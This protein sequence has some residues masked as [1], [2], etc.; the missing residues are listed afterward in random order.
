MLLRN[1]QFTE[2]YLALTI[3]VLL[4]SCAIKSDTIS[5]SSSEKSQI[6]NNTHQHVMSDTKT[7]CSDELFAAKLY[8]LGEHSFPV[9]TQNQDAQRYMNQGLNFSYGFNHTEA[10]CAF[11]EAANLDPNLAMAYWGQALV[12]G[13]NINAEMNATLEMQAHTLVQQAK[14]LMQNISPREQVLINALE[15]RY[16]GHAKDRTTNNK[17][18]AQ[19]MR[20]A[21]QRFPDDQDIAVLFVEAVMDLHSWGYWMPDDTP[22]EGI[23]EIVGVTEQILKVNPK[24]PGAL[25]MYIHLMEST[26][27]P[28]KAEQ[29]ADTLL[30]LVPEAGHLVHMT[31]HIYQRVGR[32]ADAIKSNQMAIAVDESYLARC[33]DRGPYTTTYYPH[34]IHFLWYAA[35]LDGQSQLAIEAARKVASKVDDTML[36]EIP[37]TAFFRVT[38]YWALARF[39]YWQE[40]LR[41]PAPPASN[42]FLMGSWHYVRGLAQVATQ[43]I[44][45]AEQELA[46]LHTVLERL[47]KDDPIISKNSASSI[48]RIAAEVLAGEIAGAKN[49]FE[50]AILHLDK[51]IRLDDAL[52]YTEPPEFHFPP[53]LALGA[54]LLKAGRANEAETVYWEDLK[55][56]RNN[57][58]A[59]FGLT[60]ALTA[61]N[62]T[63][64]AAIVKERFEQSW[65]R[66]DVELKASRFGL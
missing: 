28:E 21:H 61:Q 17:A 13:P 39:G 34:N 8:Q 12:L 33:Q 62:K 37:I 25:H 6:T 44:S 11:R 66:T 64:R 14:S 63:E 10:G 31:S 58:W 40:I 49:Q 24:H 23:A 56:V 55:Y 41:E 20:K 60:Q 45:Q 5:A 54:I 1:V 46:K 3:G 65:K 32:Y 38:P 57:G 43:H 50:Q 7:A 9:T 35:T 48:L 29:S 47:S 19:A 51:A 26:K 15:K 53:R 42:L 2:I 22:Y 59:L 18:Y 30:T 16:T 27:N 36:N 52:L 4:Q